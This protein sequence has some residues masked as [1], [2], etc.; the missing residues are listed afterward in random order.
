MG[1]QEAPVLVQNLSP[2]DGCWW[3]ERYLAFEIEVNSRFSVGV[4]YKQ[5]ALYTHM[6]LSKNLKSN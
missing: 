5:N 1:V 3:K 2:V 6:K 4:G